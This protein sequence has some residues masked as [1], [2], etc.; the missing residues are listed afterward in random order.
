MNVNMNI[1]LGK[2]T[3]LSGKVIWKNRGAGYNFD[4]L[5]LSIGNNTSVFE[6]YRISLHRK[7]N[8]TIPLVLIPRDT[9]PNCKAWF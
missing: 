4:T 8:T 6:C 1:N 3:K 7:K 9:T 2:E 5:T